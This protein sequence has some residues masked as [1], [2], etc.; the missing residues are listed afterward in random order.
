MRCRANTLALPEV[1][2]GTYARYGCEREVRPTRIP[3]RRVLLERVGK[4][5]REMSG[6]IN[7][8]EINGAEINGRESTQNRL[9]IDRSQPFMEL[10]QYAA[11]SSVCDSAAIRHREMLLDLIPGA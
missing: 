7:G 10:K 5:T 8:A 11:M 1:E 6:E 3:V 4:I 9:S 2:S